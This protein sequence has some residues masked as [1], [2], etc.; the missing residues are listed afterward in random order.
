MHSMCWTARSNGSIELHSV[1]PDLSGVFVSELAQ[2]SNELFNTDILMRA[3]H[4]A[5]G[6]FVTGIEARQDKVGLGTVGAYRP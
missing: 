4:F 5:K 1:R 6:L 2:A 3:I